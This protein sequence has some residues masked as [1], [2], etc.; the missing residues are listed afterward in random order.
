MPPEYTYFKPEEVIGLDPTFV[1]KLDLARKVAGIPFVITSGFRSPEKEQ[2]LAGGCEHSAHCQGLAVDL[3]VSNDHEV[4]LIVDA[5]PPVGLT[6][7]GIY[8]DANNVPTHVHIDAS[9][10]DLHVPE[11]IWTRKEGAP[12]SAPATA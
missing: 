8:S 6:R 7:R 10:D 12:Y 2:S 11:V 4:A 9:T 3:R 5:C 1:S